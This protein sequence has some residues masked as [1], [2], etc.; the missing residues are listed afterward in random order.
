MAEQTQTV[1]SQAAGQT[2]TTNQQPTEQK[3]D[4]VPQK[5]GAQPQTGAAGRVEDLPDWAQRE[6]KEARQ[7]A[8]RYRNERKQVE[9]AQAKAEEDRLAQEA[10]W[11]KLADQRKAKVEEL[12]PKAELADKLSALVLEQYTAEITAWPEQVRNMAPGDEADVLTKLDWMKR[13]KPLALQLMA[14]K[15]PTPGNGPKPKPMGSAGSGQQEQRAR[16]EQATWTRR[17]F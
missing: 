6:L 5:D 1:E 8:Q 7:E 4:A 15:T 9:E 13:A 2:P 10:Q 16:T 11:Q 14:D 17:Q 12:T 3:P